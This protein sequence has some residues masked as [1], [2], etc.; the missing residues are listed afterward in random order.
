MFL[1]YFGGIDVSKGSLSICLL[2][3][4]QSILIEETAPNEKRALEDFFLRCKREYKCNKGNAIF[5]FEDCGPITP[6]LIAIAVKKGFSLWAES[7]LRIKRSL[8]IQRGK[9]D[10]VNAFRI[11]QCCLVNHIKATIYKPPRPIIQQLKNLN[12]LRIRLLRCC[13]QLHLGLLENKSFLKEKDIRSI[14]GYCT[15]SMASLKQDFRNV[16]KTMLAVIKGDERLNRLYEILL[17]VQGVGPVLAV[18]LIIV[19]NEFLSFTSARKFAC[20][21]GIAPF[22][23]SSGTSLKGKTKVSSLSNRHIKSA[24]HMPVMSLLR[25]KGDIRDYFDRKVKEGHPKI[26]VVNAIK[27]K[28]VS[29]IFS[30]VTQNRLYSIYPL[31]NL[32]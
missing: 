11:A 23:H 18:E 3:K 14:D 31:R 8:G 12:T 27:N 30:C 10:K 7:A 1:K 19:T 25:T 22:E 2:N 29:R 17:S 16:E 9:S 20:Y 24:L 28:L 26:S 15:E 5:C 21:C 6:N 13:K 4:D 32:K